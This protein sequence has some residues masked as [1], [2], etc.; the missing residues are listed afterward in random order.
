MR[1]PCK[2]VFVK[3]CVHKLG[4]ASLPCCLSICYCVF[5]IFRLWFKYTDNANL[6]WKCTVRQKYAKANPSSHYI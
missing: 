5:F 3:T 4:F 1:D 6:K 2:K